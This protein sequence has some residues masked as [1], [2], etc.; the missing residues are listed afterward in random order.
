MILNAPCGYTKGREKK[1]RFTLEI[2]NDNM[3]ISQ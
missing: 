1:S 3:V 2:P